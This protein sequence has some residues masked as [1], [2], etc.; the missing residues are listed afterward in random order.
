MFE[1]GVGCKSVQANVTDGLQVTLEPGVGLV[2]TLAR[3]PP[4]AGAGL[5]LFRSQT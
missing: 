4:F 1:T 2:L 3:L 5:G